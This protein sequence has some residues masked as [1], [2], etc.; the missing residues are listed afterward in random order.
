VRETTNY[1][2]KQS[3]IPS[4]DRPPAPIIHETR[5]WSDKKQTHKQPS[6]V[7]ASR[8]SRSRSRSNH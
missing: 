6:P 2:M 8:R 7:S 1:G 4:G 5:V 3:R